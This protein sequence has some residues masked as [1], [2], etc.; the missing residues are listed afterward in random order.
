MRI[1]LGT[2]GYSYCSWVGG[3]YP[4][5]TSSAQMLPYYCRQFPLVELNYTYYRVPMPRHLARLARQT[6]PG[7]QFL[8]KLHQSISHEQRRDELPAFR[9]A[10]HQLERPGK[11]LG[12]LCQFPQA[13]QY[14]ESNRRWV[15]ELAQDLTAH[16]LAV[17]FRHRSWQRPDV[18]PWLAELG[19][20]LVA[21]D[22]PDLPGLYP[23]GLVRSSSRIY[24]RLHSRSACNWYRDESRYDYDYRDEEL[25]EWIAALAQEPAS[26]GLILFNNCQRAQAA[27]NARRMRVLLARLAPQLEVV[28]PPAPR[29]RLLFD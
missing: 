17:E 23:R 12:L 3:F 13:F 21:V 26:E 4:S 7:F 10:L 1:W 29:E 18:P 25:A 2:S 11:L 9:F 15:A 5:R 24:L 8:V 14:S 6:P 20:D 16:R 28:E 22:V 19:I 27:A